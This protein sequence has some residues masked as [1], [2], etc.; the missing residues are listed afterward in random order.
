V[1]ELSIIMIWIGAWGLSDMITKIPFVEEH[2]NY[3]Y[4]LLILIGIYN[5]I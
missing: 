1:D 2:K 4:L 3:L 5:K